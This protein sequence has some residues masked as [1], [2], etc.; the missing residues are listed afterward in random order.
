II[1]FF[2]CFAE[3]LQPLMG[4]LFRPAAWFNFLFLK[5]LQKKL[6]DIKLDLLQIFCF[7]HPFCKGSTASYSLDPPPG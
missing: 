3:A 2:D 4:R 1:L 5:T 6:V 7:V